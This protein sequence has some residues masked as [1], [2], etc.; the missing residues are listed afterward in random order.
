MAA[1]ETVGKRIRIL[2]KLAGLTQEQFASVLREE[3]EVTRGAVG[4]W[5]YD[6]GISR[7]NLLAISR[8]FGVSLDWLA[9]GKGDAPV[10]VR[11][12]PLDN[13]EPVAGA[14]TILREL[15]TQFNPPKQLTFPHRNVH[16]VHYIVMGGRVV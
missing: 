8:K 3:T 7:D 15:P 16:S 6:K 1:M 10:S 2:R 5:E 14:G 12:P 13:A 9:S 4:N 11:T